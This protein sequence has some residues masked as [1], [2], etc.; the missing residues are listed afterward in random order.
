MLHL[1]LVLGSS[2]PCLGFSFSPSR[3]V[4]FWE[5]EGVAD[6]LFEIS[7]RWALFFL[8]Q[9]QS[10]F[11]V[12]NASIVW[13]EKSSFLPSCFQT[14][15]SFLCFLFT[16]LYYLF[17]WFF[18]GCFF[19]TIY[20]LPACLCY[21]S[22]SVGSQEYSPCSYS[23]YSERHGESQG[24]DQRSR[25]ETRR[26]WSK[27]R[28]SRAV[29]LPTTCQERS[30]GR[31]TEQGRDIRKGVTVGRFCSL[32]PLCAKRDRAKAFFLSR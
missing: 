5:R 15:A 21:A 11:V 30:V 19:I 16:F 7:K 17:M 4:P 8:K 31:R 10:C 22:V 20:F 6:P 24:G 1:I 18:L 12:K 26:S 2:N 13:T 25:C 23:S 14:L 27:N 32:T 28:R 29:L 9:D 3:F